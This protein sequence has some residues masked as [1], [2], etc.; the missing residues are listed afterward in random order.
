MLTVSM[1]FELR[2]KYFRVTVISKYPTFMQS[3]R[4]RSADVLLQLFKCFNQLALCQGIC[5]T[6]KNIDVIVDETDS[7][8]KQWRHQAE[9]E[10]SLKILKIVGLYS[11]KMQF[12]QRTAIEARALTVKHLNNSSNICHV[13]YHSEMQCTSSNAR[14]QILQR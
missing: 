4:L 2:S 7:K 3:R 5:A 9:S 14:T 6:R 12:N 1:P 11:I 10:M 13:T 8:L